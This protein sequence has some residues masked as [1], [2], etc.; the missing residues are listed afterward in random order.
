LVF[1]RGRRE[2]TAE[3]DSG[4]TKM[5]RR[6]RIGIWIGV[7][8]MAAMLLVPPWQQPVGHVY[9]SYGYAFLFAPSSDY[10]VSID[11]GRLLIQWLF[12]AIVIG[13]WLLTAKD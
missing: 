6:Q 4:G 13:A 2:F 12:V 8:V 7:V 3:P 9:A 5:N 11:I 10:P 1:P